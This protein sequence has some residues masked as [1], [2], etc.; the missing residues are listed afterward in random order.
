MRTETFAV[1]KE[2]AIKVQLSS[3]LLT[4]AEVPAFNMGIRDHLNSIRDLL[5]VEDSFAGH[6]E[7]IE[8]LLNALGLNI[9]DPRWFKRVSLARKVLCV[10][11]LCLILACALF[12]FYS[13]LVTFKH[14][15]EDQL[16]S[17]LASFFALQV[18]TIRLFNLDGSSWYAF[19]L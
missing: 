4:F 10:S 2:T 11:Y 5:K 16:S 15:L 1:I 17:I 3:K 18:R 12:G 8:F 13:A 19:F 6:F 9:F 14:S 7:T